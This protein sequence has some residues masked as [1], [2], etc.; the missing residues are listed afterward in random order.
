MLNLVNKLKPADFVWI[1]TCLDSDDVASKPCLQ[2]CW[3]IKRYYS[4]PVNNADSVTEY[5]SLFHIMCRQ[6]HSHFFL[7]YKAL[8][9]LPHSLHACR[10]ESKCRLIKEHHLR[11]VKQS[12]GN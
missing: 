8:Y 10:V 12:A 11:F 9:I 1:M 6:N 3:S 4:F 7:S 5:V 2:R